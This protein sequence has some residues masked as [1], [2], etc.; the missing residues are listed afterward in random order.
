LIPGFGGTQRLARLVGRGRAQELVLTGDMVSA[1]RALGMGLV[2]R[3]VPG[4]ELAQ[5]GREMASALAAKSMLTLRLALRSVGEG[6]QMAQSGGCGLEASLFGVA[7]A[8]QDAR[9]GCT[10]FLGKRKPEFKDR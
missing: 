4:E 2:N 7:A 3:V 9:E 5:A 6:L 8:S 10:A 1:D